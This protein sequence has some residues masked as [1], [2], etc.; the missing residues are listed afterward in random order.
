MVVWNAVVVLGI[1]LGLYELIAIHGD[2]NFR[3]SHWIGHGVH[4]IVLMM[5]ALFAVFNW[6]AFLEITRLASSGIPFLSNIWVGRILIGLILNFKMHGVSKVVHGQLA[7]R[8]MAEHWTHTF[9]ISGLV[10][11][12]PVYWPFI[13][14]ALPPWL[15]F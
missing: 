3:G 4:S 14:P 7:A 15:L 12:A 5:V 8:G 2:L 13:E 10:V 11:T 9:L 6:P 1:I